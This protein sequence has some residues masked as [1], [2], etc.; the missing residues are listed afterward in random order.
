MG[1]LLKRAEA[2]S[3]SPSLKRIKLVVVNTIS[4]KLFEPIVA[5]EPL[6]PPI[7]W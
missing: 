4:H 6:V 5:K 1:I 2:P 7:D 3:D